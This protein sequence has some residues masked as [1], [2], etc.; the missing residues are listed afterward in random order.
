MRK[1][2]IA[3]AALV[4]AYG[5]APERAHAQAPPPP[6]VI[7]YAAPQSLTVPWALWVLPAC[8]A[9]ILLSAGVASFKDNRPLTNWEAY[10]CG[11]L[12]WIPMPAKPK[13]R[14]ADADTL[15]IE[16]PRIG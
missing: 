11:L 3:F 13:K 5:F 2:L 4:V 16:R 9:S 14:H 12:Y 1:V 10:T 6:P 8:S 15:Y 7:P